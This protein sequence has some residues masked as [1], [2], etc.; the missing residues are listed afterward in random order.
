MGDGGE[1]AGRQ[2]HGLARRVPRRDH[3]DA[4]G[5]VAQ[6]FTKLFRRERHER[7]IF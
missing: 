1:G 3:G 6:G 7:E 4:T 2:A 5:E